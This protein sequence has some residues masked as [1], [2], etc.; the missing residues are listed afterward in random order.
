MTEREAEAAEAAE[1]TAFEKRHRLARAQRSTA[2]TED[3]VELISDLMALHGEVRV[4]E[5]ARRL[6]VSH[7]T[8]VKSVARLKRDGYVTSRPYRGIFLTEEGGALADRV[9]AR[10]QLVVQLLV[11][12]GVAREDAEGDAEGIEHHVSDRTLAAFERFLARRKPGR[13]D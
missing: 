13:G 7:P 11:E 4:T 8:A 10:H 3:Y 5:I 6:G 2:L 9:R 12:V 1:E